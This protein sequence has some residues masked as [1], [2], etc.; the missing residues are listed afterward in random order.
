MIPWSCTSSWMLLFMLILHQMAILLPSVLTN[1]GPG[2]VQVALADYG[3]H[4][5]SGHKMDYRAQIWR[6]LEIVT[7]SQGSSTWLASQYWQCRWRIFVPATTFKMKLHSGWSTQFI[8]PKLQSAT[9]LLNKL[10]RNALA[11]VIQ[12]SGRPALK[13]LLLFEIIC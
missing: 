1:P 13:L 9:F 11:F 8:F 6:L 10:P 2:K 12:L 4:A 7:Y 3:E 5:Q